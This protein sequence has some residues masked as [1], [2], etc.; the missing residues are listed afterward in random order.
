MIKFKNIRWKNLLSTGNAWTEIE[1]DTGKST[2]IIGENG[3]GK[4]TILDAICYGLFGKPFRKVTKPSLV[5][6][7][8]EKNLVVEIVFETN[9]REYR[10]LRGIKPNVFEIY[11]N[12]TLINQTATVKDYQ[13]YLEKTILKMNYK[14]FTS[15]VILGSASFT[16]FM[17]LSAADRRIVVEDLLDIQVFST[18]NVLVRQRI[19]ENKEQIQKN[20]IEYKSEKS[21]HLYVSNNI[22]AMLGKNDDK[23]NSLRSKK[24]ELE[25]ELELVEDSILYFKT[26]IAAI[27]FDVADKKAALKKHSKLIGLKGQIDNNKSRLEREIN[28]YTTNNECPSCQ[29]I[30]DETFKNDM[31][32]SKLNT[33]HDCNEGLEK[34]AEGITDI[35]GRINRLDEEEKNLEKHKSLLSQYDASKKSFQSRIID[36]QK[37]IDSFEK[38][39]DLVE[40]NKQLLAV[41]ENNINDLEENKALLSEQKSVLEITTRLLKDGGI[42]AKIIK[43]YL[44][45]IN[46][47]VNEYLRS[48]EFFVQFHLDENFGEKLKARH[49]DDFSYDNF[50]EGE[51]MKIDIALIMT[52][53]AIAKMR[54][55]VHTNL[56]ILDEIFDSSLD[57]TSVDNLLGILNGVEK[58]TNVVVI[59]HKKDQ[60][61]EKFDRT[62]K[63]EKQKNFSKH[64]VD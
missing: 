9:G 44:P 40:T 8:N 39:N 34:L 45:I 1:L 64:T 58:T 37:E 25:K 13:D 28:F 55:S 47:R 49:L 48:L 46:Q 42:K 7:V 53:R 63:F 60:M 61:I 50:S 22:K 43:Q 21:K 6:S 38:D 29:Q 52:W 3:A 31:I 30:I 36:I 23:L 18:M 15:I 12:N 27:H 20:S 17:K 59:S 35:V 4:S 11:Q 54:N 14:S 16:P 26:E 5:N 32:Q 62:I 33:K 41:T 24:V 19:L 56:L 2:L 51:K 10:V 57:T